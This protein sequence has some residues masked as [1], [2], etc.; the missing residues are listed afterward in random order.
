MWLVCGLGNPG[1]AYRNNRHNVGFMVV[2]RLADKLVAGPFRAKFKGEFCRGRLGDHELIL[3]KPQTFMNLSG[4]S[5]RA[6]LDFFKLEPAALVAVHD[7]LDL[8]FG[9]L[10]LKQGGGTAGHNGLKSLVA[11]AG[12]PDF[13]RVRVGIGRPRAGVA[14]GHVLGDFSSDESTQLQ[15]VLE[16]ATAAVADIPVVGISEAMNRHNRSTT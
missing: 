10:K 5:V 9:T 2:E 16:R 1:P 13:M 8:P 12:T 15:D 7:E 11:H 3:L 6:A 14:H 4:E